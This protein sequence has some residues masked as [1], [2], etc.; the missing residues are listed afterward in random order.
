M[1]MDVFEFGKWCVEYFTGPVLSEIRL[2]SQSV[3]SAT[4]QFEKRINQMEAAVQAK[5][6]AV[7]AANAAHKETL[8]KV[9]AEVKDLKVKL[10][11]AGDNT[12]AIAAL[13]A[14]FVAA[15]DTVLASE[16]TVT[17]AIAAVDAENADAVVVPPVE[18]EPEA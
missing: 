15:L 18:P 1:P 13:N 6:D 17:D 8:D 14:E 16:T 12:E 9:L 10:E 4:V 11:Q 7:L 2:V 3:A 5:L